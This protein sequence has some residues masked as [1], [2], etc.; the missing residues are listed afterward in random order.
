[1]KG[2]NKMDKVQENIIEILWV[3]EELDIPVT[4]ANLLRAKVA[5]EG[6]FDNLS[7][8]WEALLSCIESA[9]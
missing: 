8:R 1:M 7:N 9:F 3:Y 5:V 6:L 4:P 2:D